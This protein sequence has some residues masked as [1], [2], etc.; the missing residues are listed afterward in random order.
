MLVDTAYQTRRFVAAQIIRGD[1]QGRN[2]DRLYRN[3]LPRVNMR[4]YPGGHRAVI[5]LR[6]TLH[7]L[8]GQ[9]QQPQPL[10]AFAKHVSKGRSRQSDHMGCSVDVATLERE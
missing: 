2:R 3:P 7:S 6:E 8:I 10:L 9:R 1:E 5:R 4:R